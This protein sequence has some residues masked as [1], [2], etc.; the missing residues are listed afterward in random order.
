MVSKLALLVSFATLLTSCAADT[1]ANCTF[2]DVRGSWTFQLGKGGQDKTVDCTNFDVVSTFQVKLSYPDIAT[3]QYGNVGFWTMIYNQGFEVVVHGRKFFAFSK[4]VG[5]MKNSTSYCD[6]TL[7]GWSHD[8]MG[9]DWVCYRGKKDSAVKPKLSAVVTKLDF[10]DG[11]YVQDQEMIADINRRQSL[12]KAGYYSEFEGRS[13]DAMV[14]MAGGPKSRISGRPRAVPASDE[15]KADAGKLPNEWDWRKVDGQNFVPAV[16]N[17]QNCGSCYAFGSL[18]MIEA[19]FRIASNNTL[20]PSFSPQDVV[21]CSEY[22]QGC[23]GGFPYLI[24]GKY[25][26]DFGLVEE[27]CKP[28]KN[29]TDKCTTSTTCKRYYATHYQYIGGFYGACNEEAM[30]IALVKY[31]PLAVSFEVYD[32][33]MTYKQGIYDHTGLTN[34]FSPFELTNHAVLLVGYGVEN[35]EPYWSIKNSWGPTWGEGGYFR[36]RR[37][38]DTCAVESIAVQSFPIF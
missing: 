4:Y 8:V 16:R 17:Q 18:G 33:F 13:M 28:Y 31:G 6:Q 23:D 12:W 15:L 20:Q 30:K 35:N 24:A 29:E 1:P 22:S 37:G 10:D 14:K 32:D 36:I 19:R 34:R 25:S 2:E 38:R 11:V 21:D 26:E 3:D 27:S 9:H 5:D 7:P